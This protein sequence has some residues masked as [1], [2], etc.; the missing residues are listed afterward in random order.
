MKPDESEAYEQFWQ[1]NDYVAGS[2]DGRRDFELLNQEIAKKEKNA[3]ANRLFYLAL[4]PSVFEPV[5]SS[6]RNTCM[7]TRYKLIMSS[8]LTFDYINNS[9]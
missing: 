3:A 9:Y 2:Y 4:P 1:V 7:A 8:V 6:L 5:T